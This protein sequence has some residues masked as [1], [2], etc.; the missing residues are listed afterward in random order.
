LYIDQKR[1]KLTTTSSFRTFEDFLIKMP[2]TCV[3]K[4]NELLQCTSTTAQVASDEAV[5]TDF[6]TIERAAEC[7][8]Q[9]DLQFWPRSVRMARVGHR[10]A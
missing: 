5:E 3:T 1:S 7:T 2:R 10:T 9:S 4:E 6:R 8:F